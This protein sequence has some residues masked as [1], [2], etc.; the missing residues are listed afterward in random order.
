MIR[1]H[2]D[3]SKSPQPSRIEVCIDNDDREKAN[4]EG[5]HTR[6]TAGSAESGWWRP[7]VGHNGGFSKIFQSHLRLYQIYDG[8][9]YNSEDI[10]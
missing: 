10:L 8:I 2:H 7:T 3:S 6:G 5:R 9:F 4:R 1:L